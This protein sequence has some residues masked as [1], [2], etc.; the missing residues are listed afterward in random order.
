MADP[1]KS[2]PATPRRKEEARKRGQVARSGELT[3]A[4]VLLAILIFFR[5]AGAG[6]LAKVGGEAASWWGHLTPQDPTTEGVSLAGV[7][8]L[9]RMGAILGP[10]LLLVAIVAIA[11]NIGQIGVLFTTETLTPNF[12][13]LNPV[14]G[15]QRIFSQ[16]TAVELVKGLVKIVLI[17]WVVWASV[18]GA[19]DAIMLMSVQPVPAALATAAELTWRVGL[20]VV[21]VLLALAILDYAYQRYA[22]ERSLRMS[23]QEIKDEYRQLEGDPLIKA[24]IR[25]L[26][27]EASRRRMI[28]EVPG[29][30]VVITNPVHVAV[31]IKYEPGVSKAPAIVARGA[32][33][34]AERIK[35]V[36][37]EAGVPVHEDPPLARALY[38]V[39]AGTD[40]P[41]A[42]Y[43]A[44]AHVLAL[45]YHSGRGD[46]EERVLADV[47]ERR[48]RESA[49]AAF[50]G[51]GLGAAEVTRG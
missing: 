24:R 39:P 35:T 30:D 19:F 37:R 16:R 47:L 43:Q 49:R 22:W 33:L 4:L 23:R 14:Q 26:Q 2:E 6:F 7:A 8:L 31:A 18:R 46:K 13:H 29:A 36:A 50:G 1:S 17:S 20:R 10:L 44:V 15:F 51:P 42:L 21:M 40:L 27:R 3:A 25:Q 34:M 41:P 5:I 45:V 9:W 28:A 32:R 48:A 12:D 11:G 38:A